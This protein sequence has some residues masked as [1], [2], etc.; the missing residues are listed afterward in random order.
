MGISLRLL[1][2][3]RKAWFSMVVIVLI[4][5]LV[6]VLSILQAWI[7]A[8]VFSALYAHAS[9]KYVV[10][11]VAWLSLVLLVRPLFTLLIE[12]FI[13]RCGLLIKT[14]VRLRLV[15]H[16]NRLGPFAL[17]AERSGKMETLIT[18]GIE[19]LEDYFGRYLPQVVVTFCTVIATVALMF[20]VDPLV[21]VGAGIVAIAT[22]LLP[23]LWDK[24]LDKRNYQHWQQYAEL[25]AD[26]VDSMQGMS[27]LQ[28]FNAVAARRDKIREAA[29]ELLNRTMAQMRISLVGSG[30]TNWVIAAGPV[31]ILTLCI[32]QS[33]RGI[34]P[35]QQLF[36][37]MFLAFEIFKP[38]LQLG[39]YWH[40]GYHG[41]ATA[42]TA[43]ELLAISPPLLPDLPPQ[44]SPKNPVVK[45][46]NVCFS[47]PHTEKVVLKN[48]NL[49]IPAGSFVGIA[50]QSGSGKSTLAGLMQRLADPQQGQVQIG[51][52]NLRALSSS[53]ISQLVAVVPQDPVLFSGTIRQNLT[54]GRADISDKKLL[55][56]CLQLGLDD[57]ATPEELLDLPVGE[58]GNSVSGGQRQRLALARALLRECPIL[59]LDES[60]SSLDMHRE[61][62]VLDLLNK[63]R[64]S[65][66]NE[67]SPTV[68]AI[69][70]RLSTIATADKIFVFAN[71]EIVQEG[72][73]Q[74]LQKNSGIYRNLWEAESELLG[75]RV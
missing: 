7:L 69:A 74:E 71:G 15:E 30:L 33:S 32:V 60:T 6:S 34:L 50:G 9:G 67:K 44:D 39:A 17:S 68:I 14:D 59:I 49:K 52:I 36:W 25:N 41:I 18:D 70:H 4:G 38:F 2:L 3:G 57:L 42:K 45:F 23:R 1:R 16:M 8:R 75:A 10:I 22:P 73:P 55:D 47:Y 5:L 37:A 64:S 12:F 62:K 19:L 27:T 46:N 56:I 40:Q 24:A 28:L 51:D 48:I 66:H 53:Q 13:S 11:L 61:Q 54:L 29:G 63:W 20:A 31:V 43:L 58:K 21:A 35:V 26:V 72:T 65:L